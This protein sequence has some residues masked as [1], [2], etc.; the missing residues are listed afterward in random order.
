MAEFILLDSSYLLQTPEQWLGSRAFQYGDG[1]FESMLFAQQQIRFVDEHEE[2]LVEGLDIL[3]LNQPFNGSPLHYLT[4]I[5]PKLVNNMELEQCRLKLMIW[6]M[7]AGRYT[8]ETEASAYALLAEN[9]AENH[10][11]IHRLGMVKKQYSQSFV[12]HPFKSLSSL[13]YVA[14]GL[15]LRETNFDT[16]LFQTSEGYLTESIQANLFIL[17]KE[18]ILSPNPALGMVHGVLLRKLSKHLKNVV[19]LVNLR[20]EDLQ[21]DDVLFLGNASGIRLVHSLENISFSTEDSKLNQ[22]REELGFTSFR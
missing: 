11:P 2:R 10:S 6:R 7:G 14:A 21:T 19:K 16:L 5:V 8:P 15:E 12:D 22:L 1:L 13:K 17:R 9:Y 18:T 4:E 3:K 20:I